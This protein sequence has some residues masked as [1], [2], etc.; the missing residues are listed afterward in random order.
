MS[1]K[2]QSSECKQVFK[3][4]FYFVVVVRVS[5]FSFGAQAGA[6]KYTTVIFELDFDFVHGLFFVID[7]LIVRSCIIFHQSHESSLQ[8]WW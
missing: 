4:Y 2:R 1:G 7:S 5:G 3:V 6:S 8:A